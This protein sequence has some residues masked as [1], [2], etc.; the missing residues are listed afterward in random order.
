MNFAEAYSYRWGPVSS[1]HAPSEGGRKP[2]L[3]IGC[4]SSPCSLLSF[5]RSRIRPAP[6]FEVR[7]RATRG[8]VAFS[9]IRGR[10][11][12]VR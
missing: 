11:V 9:W 5:E 2:R 4:L 10:I 8:R 3:A 12:R 6:F 7:L 1:R